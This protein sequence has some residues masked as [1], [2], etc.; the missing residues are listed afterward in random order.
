[1]FAPVL[2]AFD[3]IGDPAVL[4][5]LIKSLLL[6]VGCFALLCG[7]SFYGLHHVLA[8]HGW[9][10]WLAGLLGGAAALA[11][12]VWL[13]LPVAVVIASAF[14]EPVCRAVERR[15]YPHVQPCSGARLGAQ[16][17][18]GLVVGCTVLALNLVALLL[19]LLI[20]GIG[21]VLGWGI[22]AWAL[23]R[24]MFVTV[25]MRRMSRGEAAA[26]YRRNRGQIWLQGGVLTLIGTVPFANLLLPVLAPACMIHLLMQQ[27]EA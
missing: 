15:W 5:V 10:A 22:T 11:A 19:A 12:G 4:G 18:D 25:A 24:G 9:L 3:Q 20:P 13:F 21:L 16:L 7:G 1:M 26:L 2:R 14:M 23:A 6:S 17:W 27:F 8:A